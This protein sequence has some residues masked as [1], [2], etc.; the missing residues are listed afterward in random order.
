[1]LNLNTLPDLPQSEFLRDLL[2]RIWANETVIALWLGGSLADGRGD[3]YSDIDLRIAV[4][5]DDLEAW[6]TVD[7]EA[8]FEQP[9]L[10][11]FLSQYTDETFLHHFILASGEIYDLY[12]QTPG[13]T[14][15]KEKRIVF[16]SRDQYLLAKLQIEQ[17]EPGIQYEAAD[18]ASIKFMLELY[19]VILHK[20]QK[21]NYRNI[22]VLN[23]EGV[24]LMRF[25]LL[26]LYYMLATGNDC[27]DLRR[28]TIHT[29]TPV[30]ETI[31]Q[32]YGDK[33]ITILGMATISKQEVVN[34]NN[35]L[36]REVSVVGRQL[37]EQ[38]DFVYPETLEKM[39]LQSW[40][41]FVKKEMQG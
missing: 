8:L 35:L 11:K 25:I 29:W 24:N 41:E 26:R 2:P 22:R 14:L 15:T 32:T 16:A 7:L 28:M 3:A 38:F 30:I 36:N 27:G 31:Q 19:W 17:Q 18:P 33:I 21:V 37:A 9:V 10:A 6:R 4:A 13:Y 1:M 20:G 12:V 34:V 23:W 5:A 39:T 40:G